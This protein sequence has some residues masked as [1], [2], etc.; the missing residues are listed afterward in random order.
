M[1]VFM[2]VCTYMSAYVCARQKVTLGIFLDVCHLI[3]L[4]FITGADKD[5]KLKGGVV[6]E[7]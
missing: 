3:F 7:V 1:Y 4:I 2:W 5:I 6:R